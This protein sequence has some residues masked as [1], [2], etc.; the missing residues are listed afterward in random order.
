M[1]CNSPFTIQDL[2]T[3]LEKY[4]NLDAYTFRECIFINFY[5]FSYPTHIFAFT[6]SIIFIKLSIKSINTM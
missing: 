6:N 3:L 1:Q 4:C 2:K 5:T